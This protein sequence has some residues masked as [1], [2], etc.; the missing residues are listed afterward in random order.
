[1]PG[2]LTH[3]R[4]RGTALRRPDS[5]TRPSGRRFRPG[6]TGSGVGPGCGGLGRF[7]RRAR[8]GGGGG[9]VDFGRGKR[10]GRVERGWN[11]LAG[12]GG[13]SARRQ[14]TTPRREPA[15][16]CGQGTAKGPFGTWR[17]AR[18]CRE[19]AQRKSGTT[20]A[21]SFNNRRQNRSSAP[22]RQAAGTGTQ[23]EAHAAA[24]PKGGTSAEISQR[25]CKPTRQPER[26]PRPR[27]ATA[28]STRQP[29]TKAERQPRSPSANANPTRQPVNET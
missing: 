21:G 28:S 15:V 23:P 8:R 24:P 25:Q 4:G 29:V 13:R 17:T 16:G 11:G 18:C 1:M 14:L 2:K 3:R 20:T 26:Q 9:G 12:W 22:H 7:T 10:I 19:P 27:N 6:R 5:Q